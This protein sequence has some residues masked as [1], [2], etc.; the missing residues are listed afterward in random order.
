MSKVTIARTRE[1][2][3]RIRN[4]DSELAQLHTRAIVSEKMIKAK[5]LE[6]SQLYT[7]ATAAEI[8]CAAWRKRF[9]QLLNY[10]EK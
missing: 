9:D 7:R 5:E 3:E 4:R 10:L 8:A 2:L 6:A 1:L